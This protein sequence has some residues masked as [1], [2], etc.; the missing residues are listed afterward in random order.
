MKALTTFEEAVDTIQ[1]LKRNRGAIMQRM[2]A[3]RQHYNADVVVPT[4]DVPGSD[5][6]TRSP[7]PLLIADAIDTNAQQASS[8]LPSISTPYEPEIS[9]KAKGQKIAANRKHKLL[10]H[11]WEESGLFA[12][13]IPRLFRHYFAYATMGYTV[14]AD[15][16]RKRVV[17]NVANPL[18]TYS[19]PKQPEDFSHPAYFGIVNIKST[20]YLRRMFPELK[21]Y[22]GNARPDEMWD[23]LEWYDEDQI[24]VGVIGTS[25]QRFQ[26]EHQM[27]LVGQNTRPKLLRRWPNRAGVTPAFV[28]SSITLDRIESAVMKLTGLVNN[29]GRMRT[30]E[31][32]AA[33]RAI[34]PDLVAFGDGQT[35]PELVNGEWADGR[36]GEINLIS[37]AK[38]FQ[39]V[40]MDPSIVSRQVTDLQEAAFMQ[41]AGLDPLSI[42][43]SR[44]ASLR[45]GRALNTMADFSMN[46]R[47]QEAQRVM[48]RFLTLG[49][50]AVIA[51]YKGYFGSK[52]FSFYS[53]SSNDREMVEVI[54]NRDM[55]TTH[56]TVYYPIPGSTVTTMQ[57]A[58]GNALQTGQMSRRTARQIN[59]ILPGDGNA[60]GIQRTKEEMENALLQGFLSFATQTADGATLVDL[61][62]AMEH[63]ENTG[64]LAA[65]IKYMDEQARKRQAEQAPTPEQQVGGIE[66]N[67]PGAVPQ[68]VGASANG[69]EKPVAGN[70]LRQI[71]AASNANIARP[72]RIPGRA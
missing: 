43:Q 34:F 70:R 50:E 4:D 47:L 11:T 33:E 57:I 54:P 53:G 69:L 62:G 27:Y 3:V 38:G 25:T 19:E 13:A 5:E 63:Y 71:L 32:I 45:T 56:N 48:Q 7:N 6:P 14:R 21:E 1:Y 49:N 24:M 10:L 23:M 28:S 29:I 65:A 12:S 8:V 72:N 9:R 67:N 2:D 17:I 51:T 35:T 59:P 58:I 20:T 44:G 68:P 22:L 36:D 40:R 52:K 55:A 31:A 41:S 66:P 46:P 61:A 26:T 39:A 16:K 60:E 64:D 15:M 37:G 42:G 18:N 30:L